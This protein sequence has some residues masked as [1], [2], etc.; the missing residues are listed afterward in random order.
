MEIFAI[1]VV[2]GFLACGIIACFCHESEE[3]KARKQIQ[4]DT[5][6][7]MNERLQLDSEMLL[8]MKAMNHEAERHIST[9]PQYLARRRE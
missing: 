1:G 8:A 6:R 7:F 3:K 4:D 5:I 2:L 9:Y